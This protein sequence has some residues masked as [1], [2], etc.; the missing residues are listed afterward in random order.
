MT[1]PLSYECNAF[2]RYALKSA[3]EMLLKAGKVSEN[4]SS[5]LF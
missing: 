2:I 4:I 3:K 5:G 1:T